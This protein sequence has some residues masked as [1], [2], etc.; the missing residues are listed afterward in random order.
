MSQE[1]EILARCSICGRASLTRITEHHAGT[2]SQGAHRRETD[3]C[4]VLTRARLLG[5]VEM[6]ERDVPVREY[7]AVC[8]RPCLASALATWDYNSTPPLNVPGEVFHIGGDRIAVQWVLPLGI[9]FE[10][11]PPESRLASKGPEESAE[12]GPRVCTE[13]P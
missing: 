2:P 1:R 12:W 5:T 3:Y 9:P 4:I 11:G 10:S 7:A 6:N 13:D 8:S